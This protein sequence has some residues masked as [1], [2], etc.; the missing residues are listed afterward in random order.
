MLREISAGHMSNLISFS[1]MATGKSPLSKWT[2]R[3]GSINYLVVGGVQVMRALPETVSNPQTVSQVTQRSKFKLLSQLAA[4]IAPSI[5]YKKDG[6]TSSRNAFMKANFAQ[7]YYSGSKA[8]VIL[9][10]VQ[11]T[12]GN[13]GIPQIIA[14][15]AAGENIMVSLAETADA[16]IIA[17]RYH[18]YRKTDEGKLQLMHI[19]TVNAAGEDGT[20]ETTFPY[21]AGEIV[22]WAYGVRAISESAKATYFSFA[23]TN[24]SSVGTLQNDRALREAGVTYTMTR[25]ATLFYGE[26]TVESADPGKVRVYVTAGAGGSVQG[27]GSYD[28]GTNVTVRATPNDGYVFVGWKMA[29]SSAIVSTDAEYTFQA[30]ELVDLIAI[31]QDPNAGEIIPGDG[32]EG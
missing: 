15:R 12:D 26:E 29:G 20:F 31:F 18:L 23:V 2:G 32:D 21:N 14:D 30:N 27:A 28:I 22:I 7:V 5:N 13:A 10:N 19:R 8:A 17:M 1:T 25:G 11:L 24:G 3:V 9:E 16:S 6:L 4:E